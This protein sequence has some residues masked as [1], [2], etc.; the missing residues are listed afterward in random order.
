MRSAQSSR[1]RRGSVGDGGIGLGNGSVGIGQSLQSSPTLRSDGPLDEALFTFETENGNRSITRRQAILGAG[2]VG[3]LAALGIG[4]SIVGNSLSENSSDDFEILRVASEDVYTTEDFEEVDAATLMSQIGSFELPLGSQLWTS[5]S[6]VAAC[7]V[8]GEKGSPLSV[9]QILWLQS[10]LLQTILGQ[11]IGAAEGYEI[12]GVRATAKGL[13]WLE[14]NIMDDTWR[15][16]TASL[17]DNG[18]PGDPIL[19]EENGHG[20]EMPTL[21]MVGPYA[22]WQVL[23]RTDSDYSYEDSKLKRV[24]AGGGPESVVTVWSSTGRMCCAPYATEDAIVIAPRVDTGGVYHQLTAIKADTLEVLDTMIMPQSMRPLE[25]AWGDT[26]FSFAFD[27]IYDYGEGIA[28]LGTYTPATEGLGMSAAKS[29]GAGSA[30]GSAARSK[31][32]A[33]TSKSA[34]SSEDEDEAVDSEEEAAAKAGTITALDV[35]SNADSAQLLRTRT[36]TRTRAYGEAPWFRFPRTPNTSPAWCGSYFVVKSTTAI[37][38]IDLARQ[39]FAT[40]FVESGSDD[41]GDFLA[42]SGSSKLLVTYA[43]IENDPLNGETRTCTLVRTW[44]PL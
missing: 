30:T 28:Q 1:A 15:V 31:T 11:A 26:G 8:P 22:F 4:G 27:A 33:T 43:N 23:P 14:A 25:I 17:S 37:A 3:V 35:E 16:Y 40:L 41:Y 13:L 19:V 10:G 34:G 18:T 38:L 6:K 21:A 42:T 36:N 9:F 39:S 32:A 2:T 44:A 12:F 20:W 5:D 29:A 7:L 24:R